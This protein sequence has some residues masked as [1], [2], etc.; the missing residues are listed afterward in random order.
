MRRTFTTHRFLAI[1]A[2]VISLAGCSP[3]I[4]G[5]GAAVTPPRLND[6]DMI[7]SD[8]ARLPL[9][10][11]APK[12]GPAR[13]VILALHGFNDYS[14]FFDMPGR[15]LAQEY[16]IIS[17]AYDQRG[18]GRAPRPGTWAGV[19][20]YAQDARTAIAMLQLRHPG[21]PLYLLGESMGGAVAL[22]TMSSSPPP[23]VAGTILSAPA[24]WG[25]AT[26]PWYQ[27]LALW[28][29]AHTVPQVTL[30]GKGLHIV[31]SDN[32]DMLI[33]LGRDP[34]ILKETRIGTLFGLVNLMDA[35]LKSAPRFRSRALIMYGLKDEV[36]PATPI[37]SLLRNLPAS[38]RDSRKI[39]IYDNGYHMLLRDLQRKTVWRDVAAWITRPSNALP[40]RA[41]LR[42]QTF[43][44]NP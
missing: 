30:T 40:S 26:M 23:N 31:P 13:A 1:L 41:D 3:L 42:Y 27:R 43:R 33:R 29:G 4:V 24:V 2:F 6:A 20:A 19:N 22:V 21:L 25:R 28:I 15:F 12:S 44:D 8:G 9:R 38:G 7:M 18:F 16:N 35:G 34:L 39:A 11:W 37:K 17:Y 32:T 5:P 10:Q 14:N 36:V